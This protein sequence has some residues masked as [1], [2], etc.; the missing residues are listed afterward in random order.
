M[1]RSLPPPPLNQTGL[2]ATIGIQRR[3]TLRLL[4]ENPTLKRDFDEIV[5]D[6]YA[7]GRDLAIAKLTCQSKLFRFSVHIL[8]ARF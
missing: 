3:D 2:E 6:D 4:K 7:N 8:T 5:E 1:Q